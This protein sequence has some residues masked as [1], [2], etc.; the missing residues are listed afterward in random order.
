[1]NESSIAQE[2]RFCAYE[3]HKDFFFS[4]SV[5][6]VVVMTFILAIPWQLFQSL[7]PYFTA[8]SPRCAML[9][10][11]QQQQQ[12]FAMQQQSPAYSSCMAGAPSTYPP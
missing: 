12:P 1:M 2:E 10:Q 7:C 5:I 8:Q 4:A 3:W 6:L 11:Q 9:Q